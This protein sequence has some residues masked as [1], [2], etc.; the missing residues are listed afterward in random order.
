MND[1]E[2]LGLT[3][4]EARVYYT[5]LPMGS[6]TASALVNKTGIPDS[7]IYRFLLKLEEK[8]LILV[9]DSKPK[10][11][12]PLSPIEGLGNLKNEIINHHEKKLSTLKHVEVALSSR[13][14]EREDMPKLA[15]ILKGESNIINRAR[16][17]IQDAQKNIM[18]M[19]PTPEIYSLLKTTVED[20]PSHVRHTIGM[21]HANIYESADSNPFLPLN[22]LCFF[23][24]VD[25][26]VLLTIS[27][28]RTNSWHGIWTTETSLV[29][30]SSGYFSSSACCAPGEG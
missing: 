7:K 23:L 17:L 27:H 30:V 13:F 14:L 10:E 19:V 5:I 9:Q 3:A 26:Q 25:D 4:T 12:I 29:E 28:W 22:C 1:L 18:L 15:Y 6:A 20:L 21:Y 24:I 11:Y 2:S 8:G 16:H